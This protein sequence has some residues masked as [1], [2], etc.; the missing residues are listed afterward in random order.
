MDAVLAARLGSQLLAGPTASSAEEAVGRLLAVQG[1][2]AR[3]FRLAV[4]ARTDGVAAADVDAGLAE[5]RL[6]VAWL[7]R[8]TLH[9]VRAEDNGWLHALTTPPLR[10]TSATRLRQEGVSPEQAVRGVDAVVTEIERHGPR[11][12]DELRAALDAAGVP[13]A[14]QALVHVLLAATLQHRLLRGPVVDGEHRMVLADD[15][16]PPAPELDREEALARLAT[17]Y[18]AAHGPAADRDLATWAG[19]PL[20]DARTGLAAIATSTTV[21]DGLVD[22]ADR[23]P[24]P[25]PPPPRLLGNF[26]PLLHGWHSRDAVLGRHDSR[27]VAGGIFRSWAMVDGAPVAVW[28][29]SGGRVRIRPF[30]PLPAEVEAALSADAAAV[31]EFLGLPTRDPLVEPPG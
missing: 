28:R 14:G 1:Q 26:D 5:R 9:L 13:T 11:S 25:P 16:L 31:L 2:D 4:R 8:G 24:P 29:I 18:L 15:W 20:R 7:N 23:P 19:L 10:A 17:R 21:R 6:V 12:R 30:V 22:L 27:I 3:G